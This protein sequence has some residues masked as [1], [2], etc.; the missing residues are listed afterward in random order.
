VKFAR[1]LACL[2]DALNPL[3]VPECRN[4]E[5]LRADGWSHHP[6]SRYVTPD[7]PAGNPDDALLGDLERFGALLDA[8][9]ER[10][11][12]TTRQALY[13][14]EFAYESKEDDPYQQF[15]REQQA[16]LV[17]WTTF[18]AYRDPRTRMFSQFLLRDI[19]PRLSGRAAGTKG[20]Y[21]DFQSG[22]VTAEG[23][24][25]PAEQ[26]FRMPFWA[27]TVGDGAQRNVLVFGE[28][29]PGTDARRVVRV[30][31]QDPASRMWVPVETSGG[32]T[33]DGSAEFLTDTAGVF[34][35]SVPAVGA[36]AYRY[37]WQHGDGKWEH[38]VPVD[39]A[40]DSS[41]PPPL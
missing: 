8:L 35:R 9:H 4:F 40:A 30:E 22:L 17:G 11:R 37:A 31:R 10:G 12:I 3:A 34:L 38:S 16:R 1:A 33:C 23:N 19:D 21:R 24:A 15:T 25:K 18:L 32:E 6:Y 26:A 39:V 13:L 7:T 28:V 5:P 2:D 27:Q 36:G 41:A 20:F 29:R 14:T